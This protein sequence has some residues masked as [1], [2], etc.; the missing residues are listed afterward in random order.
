MTARVA[1][2]DRTSAPGASLGVGW[3]S[4]HVVPVEMCVHYVADRLAADFA[5]DLGDQRG[6]CRGLRMRIDD[7]EVLL[8]FEDRGIAVDDR[9]GRAMAANT[10]SA[11]FRRSKSGCASIGRRLRPGAPGA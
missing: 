5:P 11:T 9:A 4:L 7:Q 3:H 2:E 8:V 1:E 10:P 6:R